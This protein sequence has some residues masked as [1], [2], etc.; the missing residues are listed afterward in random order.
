MPTRTIETFDNAGNLV[1]TQNLT[2][3]D[4]EA[5]REEVPNRLSAV[6]QT[7][8]DWADDA[9]TTHADWPTKT[10]AQKDAINREVIRRLG[11]LCDGLADFIMDRGL[12]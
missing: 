2:L 7:L 11:V 1:T 3:T 8:R 9:A 5:F 6:S 10:A 12:A 4:E